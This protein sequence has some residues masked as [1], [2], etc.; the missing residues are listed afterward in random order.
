MNTS[1]PYSA[2]EDEQENTKQLQKKINQRRNINQTQSKSIHSTKNKTQ[3]KRSKVNSM[4]DLIH[5][6]DTSNTTT[7]SQQPSPLEESFDMLKP[8]IQSRNDDTEEDHETSQYDDED[9]ASTQNGNVDRIDTRNRPLLDDSQAPDAVLFQNP[10]RYNQLVKEYGKNMLQPWVYSQSQS[11]NNPPQ[12]NY[13][14]TQ[15]QQPSASEPELLQ[16]MNYMIHLLEE[17][18]DQKTDNVNEELILYLFLGIFVIFVTDSFTR[19]G[20]YRR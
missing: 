16:R 1:L 3:K 17:Q 12:N 2:I 9:E 4:L 6:S 20:K 13:S 18:K 15:T 5:K 7:N 19:V 14:L 8:E 10:E 11:Q